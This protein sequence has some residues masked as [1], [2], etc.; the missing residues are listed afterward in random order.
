[1]SQ[2]QCVAQP[3][4]LTAEGGLLTAED[5]ENAEVVLSA[6]ELSQTGGLAWHRDHDGVARG[7]PQD[8]G[9]T[10]STKAR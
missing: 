10:R 4:F 5:A 3:R 6:S 8:A 9:A 7:Q 1:M 2:M